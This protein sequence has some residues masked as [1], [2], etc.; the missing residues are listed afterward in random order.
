MGVGAVVHHPQ[1]WPAAML[2]HPSWAGDG[3]A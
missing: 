2:D 3:H 1:V